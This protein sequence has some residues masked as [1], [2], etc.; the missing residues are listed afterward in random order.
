V[1]KLWTHR[2]IDAPAEVLWRLLTD[3]TRWPEWGP[4]V[5]SAVLNGDRF[6]RGATGAVATAVGIEL[7]FEVTDYREGERWAWNVAGLPA[8]HHSVESLGSD[9]CRVGF[10]VP[11]VAAPY[12]AVC[13]IALRRIVEIVENETLTS[14]RVSR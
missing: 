2:E 4:S 14:E 11:W 13:E 10:G 6:D 8:T 5:R 1:K 7:R 3:P 12:L 9:R